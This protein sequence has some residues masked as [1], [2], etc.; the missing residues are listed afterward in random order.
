MCTQNAGRGTGNHGICPAGWSVPTHAAWATML[1]I[2]ETGEKNIGLSSALQGTYVGLIL[3]NEDTCPSY[4]RWCFSDENQSWEYS[5]NSPAGRNSWGFSWLASGR[6][7]GGGERIE[8]RGGFAINWT[9]NS[10]RSEYAWSWRAYANAGQINPWGTLRT[11]GLSVRC[12][13]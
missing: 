10:A 6:R 7:A 2:V 12:V 3:R 8:T 4:D 11:F 5:A 1:N 13:Q 9:S